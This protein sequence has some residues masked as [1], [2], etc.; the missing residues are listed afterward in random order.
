MNN[1]YSLDLDTLHWSEVKCSG[2]TPSPR[3]GMSLVEHSGSLYLFGGYT[4]NEE[5]SNELFSLNLKGDHKWKMVQAKNEFPCKRANHTM[6][7]HENGI[8]IIGGG[9]EIEDLSDLSYLNL[10]SIY[11]EKKLTDHAAQMSRLYLDSLYSD[12]VFLV[13]GEKIYGHK[14]LLGTRC[15]YICNMFSSGMME[16]NQKEIEITD[17]K[18]ASFKGIFI[19]EIFL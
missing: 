9:N 6:I 14:V 7:P 18:A 8:F 15:E 4:E 17:C 10:L 3:N 16:A 5:F 1:L 2:V 11:K 19:N 12:V 13:Q